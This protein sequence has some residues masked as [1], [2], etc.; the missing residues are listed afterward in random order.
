MTGPHPAPRV[1]LGGGL[2]GTN[3]DATRPVLAGLSYQFGVDSDGD[4]QDVESATIEVQIREGGALQ[5]WVPGTL[6]AIYH[7]PIGPGNDF[8]YFLG[9]IA[10]IEAHPDDERPGEQRVH[11]E[12]VSLDVDLAALTVESVDSALAAGSARVWHMA[13]W[14]DDGWQ[15]AAYP[16]RFPDQLHAPLHYT[17]K[18]YLELLDQFLRAQL[19]IRRNASYFK[20]GIGITRQLDVIPDAARE[21]A[22]DKLT[23]EPD[24]TWTAAPGAPTNAGA[25]LVEIPAS[26][27][28]A[29][30]G[31][32]IEPDDLITEVQ[33]NV[34]N[35]SVY[36]QEKKM[37]EDSDTSAKLSR[38]SVD[39]AAL[40][41]DYGIKPV[42]LDT[43]LPEDAGDAVFAPIMEHWLTRDGAQWRTKT[44]QIIDSDLL[45]IQTLAYL[46]APTSRFSAMLAVSGV[47]E[48]RPDLGQPD[49]RG[50]V[51]GGSATWNGKKWDISLTLARPPQIAP[52]SGW[53]TPARIKAN[54][55]FSPG[56]CN[57][58]GPA[59]TFAHFKRIGA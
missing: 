24:G 30:A 25:L 34:I 8:T 27:I 43:D 41:H 58:V 55:T 16:V 50:L 28:K 36:D 44:V 10:R 42:T 12:A 3:A 1:W 47:S 15:L 7:D 2:L 37:W 48:A 11:I 18:P 52:G 5:A 31:Y 49:L 35:P 57:T 54:P 39:T 4:L 14:L 13:Y 45:D 40:R 23:R 51:I 46:L 29:D 6:L 22:P 20:P 17:G 56:R 26:N 19:L 32:A 33:L 38:N 9:R 53:W 21:V 59:L